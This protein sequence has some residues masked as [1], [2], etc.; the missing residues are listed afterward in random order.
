MLSNKMCSLDHKTKS[1]L[2]KPRKHSRFSQLVNGYTPSAFRPAT[3]TQTEG[4]V[5]NGQ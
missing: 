3:N 2:C 4:G 5:K 1:S